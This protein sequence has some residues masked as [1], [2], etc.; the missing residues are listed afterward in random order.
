M[1]FRNYLTVAFGAAFLFL[2]I[3]FSLYYVHL[4]HIQ[5]LIIV[6][7]LARHGADFLGDKKDALG[8]LTAGGIITIINMGLASALYNR[9]RFMAYYIG[10][11]TTL[12][13]LLIL[14]TIIAIININ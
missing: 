6:H 7:F 9:R 1:L 10:I 11:I 12:I 2:I 5:N 14:M 3:G 13:T 4:A 8:M